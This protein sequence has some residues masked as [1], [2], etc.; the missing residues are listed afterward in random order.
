MTSD[1]TRPAK[2]FVSQ[3]N[4]QFMD[5]GRQVML[6]KWER[7]FRDKLQR[8]FNEDGCGSF[9]RDEILRELKNKG[10]IELQ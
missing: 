5:K 9:L 2:K 4:N 7:E 1:F 3:F 10:L 8:F 6:W